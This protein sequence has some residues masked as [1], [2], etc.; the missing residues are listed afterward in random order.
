M[1]LAQMMAAYHRPITV[2]LESGLPAIFKPALA[3]E[4]ASAGLLPKVGKLVKEM[5]DEEREEYEEIILERAKPLILRCGIDPIWKDGKCDLNKNEA[6]YGWLTRVD[7][8]NCYF[9][10]MDGVCDVLDALNTRS[11]HAERDDRTIGL[12][13]AGF[14]MNPLEVAVMPNPDWIRLL[15]YALLAGVVKNKDDKT[16]GG[17]E[18]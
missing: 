13:A 11:L 14:G 6:P 16:P 10:C 8:L 18:D 17:D 5:D 1:N 3:G 4:A 7:L 12:V 9:A 2:R 15:D